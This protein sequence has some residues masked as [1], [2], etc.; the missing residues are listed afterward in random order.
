MLNIADPC[1]AA[2]AYLV[3]LLVPLRILD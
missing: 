2:G 3:H 1:G